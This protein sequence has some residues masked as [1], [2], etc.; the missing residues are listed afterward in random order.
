MRLKLGGEWP[1]WRAF[2]GPHPTDTC[3]KTPG[4]NPGKRVTDPDTHSFTEGG[5]RGPGRDFRREAHS[6]P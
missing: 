3:E 6:Y 2:K 1:E 5:G 4:I